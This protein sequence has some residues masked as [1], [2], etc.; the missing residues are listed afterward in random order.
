MVD[1]S[2]NIVAPATTPTVSTYAG[3]KLLTAGSTDGSTSSRD[4]GCPISRAVVSAQPTG[5]SGTD[6]LSNIERLTGSDYGDYLT[7]DSGAMF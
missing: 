2:A 3:N 1:G 4:R 7:G 5:G 6:T